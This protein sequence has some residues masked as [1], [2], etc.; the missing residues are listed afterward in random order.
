MNRFRTKKKTKEEAPPRVSNDSDSPAPF[1]LF[2]KN[3]K[4]TEE[5]PRKEIDLATALPSSDD[6]RTSLLMTG[7]SA[8]F[9]MLKEQDDPTSKIGKASDDSVLFPKRQSR[10]LDFGFGPGLGDIAEVESIRGKAPFAR[11]DSFH[12]SE[13][14]TSGSIMDRAKPVDG[15]NLFGGRQKIY[16]LPSGGASTKNLDGGMSGRALYG[17]DVAMSSFQ[18]WRQSEKDRQPSTEERQDQVN[19]SIDIPRAESPPAADVHRKRETNSSMSSAPSVGRNSTAA[20][21][22]TSQPNAMSKDWQSAGASSHSS[23]ATPALERSV[24]RTRRLYE[25]GLLNDLHEQ[26]N[27]ALSRMDTLSRQRNLGS[28]TPDMP[29]APSPTTGL[30]TDRFGDR[31]LLAKASAPNLRSMSPPMTASSMGT[32]DFGT[33]VPS[34]PESKTAFGTNVAAP[35][36]PPI[37]ESE[38]R[39]PLTIQPNDLGKATSMGVFNKPAQQYDETKYAQ[40]QIQLQQGRE[41]P[42]ERFRTGSSASRTNGS[43]SRSRS[44]SSAQRAPFEKTE[45]ALQ[46]EPTVQEEAAFNGTFLDTEDDQPLRPRPSQSSTSSRGT[47]QRPSD[48]DHPALR[49]SAL[50]TPLSLASMSGGPSPV[51]ERPSLSASHSHQ[52]SP[53]D[54]PTLGPTTGLSGI[55]RQHLRS[56][57]DASSIYGGPISSSLNAPKSMYGQYDPNGMS[58]LSISSNPWDSQSPDWQSSY[59][60]S[61]Q[62]KL[63]SRINTIEE[64]PKQERK[65]EVMPAPSDARLRSE[66]G[67]AE[68][69]EDDF[70]RHLADGARRVRERLTSYVESDSRSVSP[71]PSEREPLPS[72]SNPLHLLISKSSRG[73]LVDRSRE[74]EQAPPPPKV[75]KMLGIGASTMSSSPSPSKRSFDFESKDALSP[76]EEEPERSSP[77]KQE[78]Q[79]SIDETAV[80]TPQSASKEVQEVE[81][82]KEEGMHAGLRAFRQARRELQKLKETETQQ[83]HQ[84]PSGP[85]HMPPSAPA[86]RPVTNRERPRGHRSPSRE[87]RPPPVAYQPRP[88]QESSYGGGTPQSSRPSSRT[89]RD[90]SGSENSNGSR[91]QSRPARLR[92]TSAPHEGLAPGTNGGSPRAMLRSPGL[93]GTDI[94]HSPIMPPRGHPPSAPPSGPL[95]GPPPGHFDRSVSGNLR[96]QPQHRGGYDSSQ[97]SPVSPMAPMPSPLVSSSAQAPPIQLSR[98]P[99]APPTPNLEGGFYKLDESTKRAVRK[100]D[101]SEPTFVSSTSRVPTVNLPEEARSRS[102]SRSGTRSRSGS[103][104]ATAST[105]NLHALAN[106]PTHAPPLPPINPKRRNM[107]G[108]RGGRKAED[109]MAGDSPQMPFA[110][111]AIHLQND[112]NSAFSV[113]DEDEGGARDRRRLRKATSE[114]N[115]MN[116]RARQTHY[117]APPMPSRSPMPGGMI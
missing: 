92:N 62:S 23:S 8:R 56:D 90:R 58:D 83:R 80:S 78:Q 100:R 117:N 96:V 113:S 93:P 44:S 61:S 30:F 2:G 76:M 72:R 35:L 50:P 6:F 16:K 98:R 52:S 38:E 54:S 57:S 4:T 64:R 95:P 3:K 84:S 116:V 67:H 20:T 104:L 82:D 55:V 81:E 11:M 74:R 109:E 108:F 91:S 105:P 29:N 88:S 94:R 51:S 19:L 7:L 89:E 110:P 111:H 27:S 102:G 34:I 1:R 32:L 70:A 25:T 112:G 99:S 106:N 85:P 68:E 33:R 31:K 46:T 48:Q 47:R 36:S 41:T 43:R 5:E 107:L 14:S 26:Q 103:L 86:P 60:D 9:S 75:N 15:N 22:V 101:I 42:T 114:A 63:N 65:E 73:S 66:S 69:K 21:S 10:M 18:R 12:S 79:Q 45:P 49:E 40:K 77:S 97:A 115:G 17:D 37:S 39:S 28:R 71:Q 24:T 53:D 87:R 13:G 59:F